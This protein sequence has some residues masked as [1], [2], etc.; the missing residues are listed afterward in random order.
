LQDDTGVSL[1]EKAAAFYRL[2]KTHVFGR[3]LGMRRATV[4]SG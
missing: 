1:L 3:F 4:A 2:I